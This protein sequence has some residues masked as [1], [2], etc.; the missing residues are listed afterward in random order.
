MGV[1]PTISLRSGFCEAL[2]AVA[3]SALILSAAITSPQIA[4]IVRFPGPGPWENSV[5]FWGEPCA[6]QWPKM[7]TSFVLTLGHGR[8]RHSQPLSI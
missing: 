4:G 7:N 3:R 5:S 2:V 6:T 1:W 8:K